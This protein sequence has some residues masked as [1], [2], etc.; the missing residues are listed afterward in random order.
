MRTLGSNISVQLSQEE[1]DELTGSCDGFTI[2]KPTTPNKRDA[3]AY[4][5]MHVT[6]E[7]ENDVYPLQTRT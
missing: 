7:L 4:V 5:S 2:D 3:N 6:R 1:R